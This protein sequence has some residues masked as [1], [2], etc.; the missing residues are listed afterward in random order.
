[1]VSATSLSL[2]PASSK[3]HLQGIFCRQVSIFPTHQHLS[4]LAILRSCSRTFLTVSDCAGVNFTHHDVIDQISRRST[5]QKQATNDKPVS[6]NDRKSFRL[7]SS[8]YIHSSVHICFID[9]TPT[10]NGHCLRASSYTN[11]NPRLYTYDI[12]PVFTHSDQP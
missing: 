2:V 6:R 1:M 5:R 4:P 7:M 9:L 12:P 8:V 10:R 3:S 11:T